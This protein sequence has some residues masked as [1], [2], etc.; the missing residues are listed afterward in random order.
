MIILKK[1]NWESYRREVFIFRNP[2]PWPD[3]RYFSCLELASGEKPVGFSND[4]VGYR[5]L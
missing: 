4:N 2:H 1:N 5:P 3:V